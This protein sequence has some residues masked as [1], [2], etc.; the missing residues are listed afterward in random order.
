MTRFARI[1]YTDSV[2][3]VQER[4]GS[5]HAMLRQLDGPDEPDPLGPV[6]QQFIAER[7]SFYLAT[8]SETGW[9][10][11]QH[12]GGPPGFLHV[13]DEHTVAFADVGGNRQFISTGNL[14][15]N[16]KV[17]L[18]LMDYAYRARLKLF[19][20]ARWQDAAE[21]PELAG[22]LARPRTDGRLERLV[23]ITVEGLS[24]NCPK[25]ITP[26]FSRAELDEVLQPIR[27]EITRLRE[28]DQTR[29]AEDGL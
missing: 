24:W 3:G 25:H 10:Y 20:R 28:V 29:A 14:R 16:D 27:D 6:E 22:R 26:R 13:L 12:R 15:H 7:D 2:R 19:G 8:V 23:T 4:N 9:P 5:A 17:A 11:I 21:A 18:F 1:A